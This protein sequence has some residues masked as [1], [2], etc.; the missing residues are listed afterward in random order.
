MDIPVE[1][2]GDVAI[3]TVPVEDLDASNT[4]DLKR[5]MTPLLEANTKV[6][7]DLA[8]IRFIDSSGLGSFISCLRI[9]NAGGGDLKLCRPQKQVQLAIELVRMH[10]ALGLF[11]TREEALRAFQT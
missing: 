10:K 11:A 7:L 2:V 4:G 5:A 6:I 9:V 3:L 8:R 1:K